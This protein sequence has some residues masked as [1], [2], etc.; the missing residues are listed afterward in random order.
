M[1]SFWQESSVSCDILA[2]PRDQVLPLALPATC[3]L[4]PSILPVSLQAHTQRP[5]HTPPAALASMLLGGGCS[6]ECRCQGH[7]GHQCLCTTHRQQCQAQHPQV[8]SLKR[9]AERCESW[10]ERRCVRGEPAAVGTTRIHGPWQLPHFQICGC[11][12]CLLLV[13]V[14]APRGPRKAPDSA[15]PTG[16][17]SIQIPKNKGKS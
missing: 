7:K 12:P 17:F 2:G 1:K 6:W 10:R 8:V 15:C 3:P 11:W 5:T 4:S 13:V 14:L 16:S 9:V